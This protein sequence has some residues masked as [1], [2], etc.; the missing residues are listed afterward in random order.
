MKI[1]FV[2]TN[3]NGYH[4]DNFHFGLAS[5]VSAV[6]DNGHTAKV[7][8]V[9][10]TNEY[11]TMEKMINDFKPEMC[12]FTSV[13]SQY[14]HVFELSKMAKNYVK[15]MIIVLG[16]VHPTLAPELLLEAPHIDYIIKGEGELALNEL[17][18]NIE[19]NG[20]D[21]ETNGMDINIETNGMAT[22]IE[23]NGMDKIL[24]THNLCYVKDGKLIQ[25][26]LLPLVEDLDILSPPNKD[27]YP[28]YESSILTT[29]MAP[30]FFT[31]GC[32][33]TCTY[34]FNQFVAEIYGRKRNFPRFRSA[35]AC[36]D[37]ILSIVVKYN[38]QINSI[39]IGDDIFGP[40]K[41]WRA[42]F[43][44]LYK[45]KVY[46]KYG[47]KFMI[48]MR[49]EM[50]QNEELPR[51]LKK[52]G[53]YSVFFGV[54]SGDDEF[55]REV[56][57]RKMKEE[58]IIKAFNNCH[59]AGLDTHCANV[60]GFP[61]ETE[62]MI[63]KTIDFNKRLKPT[64]TYVGIFYPYK[65]TSLGDQ[66]FNEGL[67]DLDKIKNND[68]ERRESV[69][70]FDEEKTQMIMYYF[71]NWVTLTQP[72]WVKQRYM[73]IVKSILKRIYLLRV[74]QIVKMKINL[75]RKRK[76]SLRQGSFG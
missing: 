5:L 19:T 74:A 51:L 56:L 29:G 60:I 71:N 13:S 50:C 25:N 15:D 55:R 12:C 59:K 6:T 45:E 53:C 36:V 68:N 69:L 75:R 27:I 7:Q 4:H 20:M 32:P 39:Y 41:K 8:V 21:I 38:E 33:Y 3:I 10:H 72:I 23:A 34:C 1:L 18:D 76:Y 52:S 63:K 57:D 73:V 54:E 70:K 67:V 44:S 61:G 49:I 2:Y 11:A 9:L 35:K 37:E 42:E 46:D 24:S 31:R 64:Q 16:G 58:A 40:N 62:D 47:I 48:L 14:H 43:C 28:Y 26:D 22:S 66:A 17:I 65:G 30:F